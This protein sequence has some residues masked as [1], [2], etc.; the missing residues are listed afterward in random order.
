LDE[1]AQKQSDHLSN[2]I[3][4]SSIKSRKLDFSNSI[5]TLSIHEKSHSDSHVNSKAKLNLSGFDS[6]HSD[7][8]NNDRTNQVGAKQNTKDKQTRLI[9]TRKL[10]DE[11]DDD[12]SSESY[13][14]DF[15]T[16]TNQK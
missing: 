14:D 5:N 15:D 16:L 1:L 2:L 11:D 13:D 7:T 12:S 3:E 8:K 6:D 10:D 4:E 9:R